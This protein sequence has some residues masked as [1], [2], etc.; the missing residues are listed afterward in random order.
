MARWVDVST[1]A[2]RRSGLIP[3]H[4]PIS[5]GCAV[6]SVSPGAPPPGAVCPR[7]RLR[8]RPSRR[9]RRGEPSAPSAPGTP[10]SP[11]SM[12]QQGR[13]VIH[14]VINNTA[15]VRCMLL[16]AAGPLN[17]PYEFEYTCFTRVC[18]TKK[19]N[20]HHR[21]MF[22]AS[23][24]GHPNRPRRPWSSLLQTLHRCSNR[25]RGRGAPLRKGA[26]QMHET[27]QWKALIP[28]EVRAPSGRQRQ[29]RHM[30]H[31]AFHVAAD[32]RG[33]HAEDAP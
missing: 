5:A 20:P 29:Q 21:L 7:A 4:R 12:R 26:E 19:S 1:Q 15:R 8:R 32:V 9:Q 11:P 2:S 24:S 10:A 28:I 6:G 33:L 13:F 25:W 3:R 18:S 30:R 17:V 16:P 23:P 31:Q 22:G 27:V 14:R